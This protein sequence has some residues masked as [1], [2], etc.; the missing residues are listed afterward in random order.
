[1]TADAVQSASAAAAADAEPFRYGWRLVPRPTPDNPHHLEQVPL[2][3]EDVLHPEAGDFIVHSDCHE[4][5]RVYVYDEWGQTIGDYVTVVRQAAEAE[6]RAQ[7]AERRARQL[8]ERAWQEAAAREAEARA[9][10]EAKARLRALKDELRRL[11]DE[12]EG[13]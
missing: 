9:R 6:E 2:W 3:L 10:Q 12:E 4:T 11:R 7:R 8:A 13:W 1:M 5:D